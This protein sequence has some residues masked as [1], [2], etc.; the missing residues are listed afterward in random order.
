MP[1]QDISRARRPAGTVHAPRHAAAVGRRPGVEYV[2]GG[3]ILGNE[4]GP[5][6]TY[7][8]YA[9]YVLYGRIMFNICYG[10]CVCER[11]V[12]VTLGFLRGMGCA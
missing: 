8:I 9:L 6:M 10:S 7:V 4:V 5:L 3:E 1:E 11:R 2:Q 12:K